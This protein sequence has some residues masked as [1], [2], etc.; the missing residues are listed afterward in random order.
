MRKH[1][2]RRYTLERMI[3]SVLA[4][5]AGIVTLTALSFGIEAIVGADNKLLMSA[6]TLLSIVAGGYATAWIAAHSPVR[7][8]VIM[9]AVQALMTFSV[10]FTMRDSMPLWGWAASIAL[11]IPAAWCGAKLLR[12]Q[13]SPTHG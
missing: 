5:I 4:V 10:M 8:A 7:H 12:P 9:G 1:A 11:T 6:Y 13:Q 3:R 2:D